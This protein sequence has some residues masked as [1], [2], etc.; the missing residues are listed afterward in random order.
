[1]TSPS[2][3][4]VRRS[5]AAL[6]STIRP[7]DAER[8]VEEEM[9][10][11]VDMATARNLQAGM[12][13]DDARRSALVTFGSRERFREE[14]REQLRHRTL[15]HLGH[16]LRFALRGLR[17]RPLVAGIVVFT[18]A[19]GIGA[20]ATVFSVIDRILLQP[21]PYASPERLVAL[22][23]HWG[24]RADGPGSVSP[25]EYF[26]Y[27]DQVKN[28]DAFGVYTLGVGDISGDREPE[29]VTEAQVSSGVLA[30]LGVTPV[31]GRTIQPAD[32]A[33]GSD[34]V[35][36][37]SGGLWT[38]RFGG[39]PD[40][41]GR[42]I[43]IDGRP[44]SIIGV[45]PPGFR[46]PDE[47]ASADAAELYVPL[48]LDRAAV[49]IRGSHFLSA[50]ARVRAGANPAGAA[51]EA[52]SVAGRFAA[53]NP[54]D[55]PA[56][57]HFGVTVISLNAAVAGSSRPTLL[58]LLAA[59]ACAR[60]I[61]CVNAAGLLLAQAASRRQEMAVRTALGAERSRLVRQ[62]LVESGLLAF[63]AGAGGVAL[64]YMATALLARIH[65]VDLP[66][67]GELTVNAP[68]LVFALLITLGSAVAF[69][70]VAARRLARADVQTS[71][72][73]TGRTSTSGRRDRELRRAL[74]VAEIAMAVVLVVAAGLLTKSFR[75]LLAVDPGFRIEHV[76]MMPVSLPQAAYASDSEA[77]SFFQQ[78]DAR[79][80]PQ[81]GVAAVG[82]VAGVP[83]VAPRGD[84]GIE[85]E[86]HPIPT[87]AVHPKA[88]WQVVTPGYFSAIGMR[89]LSGRT[90]EGTDVE[91]R[92]GAV[93]VNQT[94]AL[95]YWPAESPLGQRF[96]LGGGARPD[97][98]TVVGIVADV[99]QAGLGVTP[100]PEMY[101]AHAQFRFW[102]GGGAVRSLS[103]VLAT[104][105]GAPEAGALV[106]RE[107]HALAPDVP[108]APVQ[109]MRDVRAASVAQPR[110][111]MTLLAAIAALA[112]V[113]SL[114]GLYGI[115]AY[116]V[117]ERRREFGVRMALGASSGDIAR[118][119]LR[120]GAAITLAGTAIGVPAA[121]AFGR[122]LQ[123]FLFDVRPGDP[124]VL[125]IVSGAL[126]VVALGAAYGPARR[127]ARADPVAALRM[128]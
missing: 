41:V 1:M 36:M 14:S 86:G 52:A 18:L 98:V 72:R 19:A 117:A 77:V 12:R 107:L 20:A 9:A 71:L 73:G 87:G 127:A 53:A 42:R 123:K 99:R 4:W 111:M 74:I 96:K 122:L 113:I 68:V 28:F 32:D 7:G 3:G 6:R 49:T 81:P 59:T 128:E 88:D 119:V 89:L 46:L 43:Q 44:V 22:T 21:L 56:G 102:G 70:L 80:R 103:V 91:D 78:L 92:P 23:Q 120:E 11:H 51:A 50:V 38:R 60:V 5:L 124:V 115:M 61:A 100:E 105:M 118:L 112:F 58:L 48:A 75:R 69:G 104:R 108:A 90:L 67:L 82:A 39:A 63:V 24:N 45:L 31:L 29:R 76:M 109:S 83:L 57:N 125:A 27:T 2:F 8:R 47:M 79:I 34:D 110:F 114:A 37:I 126:A 85:F 121:L 15:E 35:A 25:A 16:D 97:T 17:R 30:A 94:M 84:M 13:R 93:V 40:I 65:P 101:L 54:A 33:P 26:D 116:T 106:R 66:R 95:R 55:Y 10:F 64:T 62:L